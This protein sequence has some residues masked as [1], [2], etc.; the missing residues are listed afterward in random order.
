VAEPGLRPVV[1]VS[2]GLLLVFVVYLAVLVFSPFFL[3]FAVAAAVALLLAPLQRSLGRALGQRPALAAGLLVLLVALAILVPVLSLGA[4][5][6]NQAGSFFAWLSPHLEPEAFQRLWRETLLERFP[7]LSNLGQA[8]LGALLSGAL[9]RL[10]TGVNSFIQAA[11]AGLTSALVDLALFLMTLFFLLKDGGQLR[12]EL[13]HVS[14]LSDEQEDQI[15]D[16]LS[17]TVKGVLQAMALVPLAQGLLAVVG[18]WL[19]GVPSALLWGVMVVLAALV[20]LVGSPL[21][22]VP[23]CVYLFVTGAPWRGFGML[24]YGVFVISMIDNVIKPMLLQ[25][26]AQIHPLL[27]FLSILGGVIAFGPLGFLVGPVVL[28]LVMSAIRIYR[29]DILRGQTLRTFSS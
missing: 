19:F 10:A 3:D 7:V 23:A 13:R 5:L 8:Q 1:L 2:L 26:A 16:H 21:G 17:R 22:W 12:A 25:E 27:G 28:S 14:P 11:V 18:F 4:L 15:F 24:L 20:P 29:L 6:G 9:T